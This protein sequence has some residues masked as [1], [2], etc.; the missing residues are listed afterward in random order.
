MKQE[1]E[2]VLVLP[3]R[4]PIEGYVRL[5]VRCYCCRHLIRE[6]DGAEYRKQDLP[7]LLKTKPLCPNCAN[8]LKEWQKQREAIEKK[9]QLYELATEKIEAKLKEFHQF[10]TLPS[11]PGTRILEEFERI[12]KLTSIGGN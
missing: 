11:P 12:F 7:D 3:S 9:L 1:N 5:K 4:F 6:H 8:H 2:F 10:I